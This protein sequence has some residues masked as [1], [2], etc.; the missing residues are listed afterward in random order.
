M[1]LLGSYIGNI[2]FI[3]VKCV[4]FSVLF[5]GAGLSERTVDGYSVGGEEVTILK[6]VLS[7]NGDSWSSSWIGDLAASVAGA[8]TM[9]EICCGRLDLCRC[10]ELRFWGEDDPKL[11]PCGSS[12]T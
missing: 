6:V 3:G 2:D 1:G 4:V 7:G 5:D 9:V 12:G 10:E 11:A 8:S